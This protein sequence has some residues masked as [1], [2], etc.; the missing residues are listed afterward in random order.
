LN[1]FFSHPVYVARP[2]GENQVAGAGFLFQQSGQLVKIGTVDGPFY[3]VG[4]FL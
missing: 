4:L 1:D 2:Y 3:P